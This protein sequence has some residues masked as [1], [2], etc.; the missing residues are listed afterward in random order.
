MATFKLSTDSKASRKSNKTLSVK[1]ENVIKCMLAFGVSRAALARLYDVTPQRLNK[2]L[3]ENLLQAQ[4]PLPLVT[5]RDLIIDNDIDKV[6]KHEAQPL[7]D[8][9]E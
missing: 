6:F 2:F 7:E 9:E 3:A 5:L 1:E 4:N 8:H